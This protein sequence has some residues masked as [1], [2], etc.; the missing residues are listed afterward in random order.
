MG[1]GEAALEGGPLALE[2]IPP[3][4]RPEEVGVCLVATIALAEVH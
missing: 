3:K 1:A 2:A 4:G